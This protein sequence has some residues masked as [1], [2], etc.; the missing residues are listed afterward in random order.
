MRLRRLR[1][2][3]MELSSL[4]ATRGAAEHWPLLSP[5]L[6]AG[7]L[8]RGISSPSLLWNLWDGEVGEAADIASEFGGVSSVAS[9]LLLCGCRLK[10]LLGMRF[11]GLRI[12]P[13]RLLLLPVQ[14]M[15]ACAYLSCL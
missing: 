12:T 5:G 7:L 11:G 2:A 15:S 6:R 1:T 3:S 8:A 14:L 4:V 13:R 9:V 10:V